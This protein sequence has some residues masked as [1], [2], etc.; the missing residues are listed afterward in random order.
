M[1]VHG[2]RRE[3][4]AAEESG[5]C[6][7]LSVITHPPRCHSSAP[8]RVCAFMCLSLSFPRPWWD[9]RER[10]KVTVLPWQQM[11]TINSLFFFFYVIVVFHSL[12]T[13]PR[14]L[15][16]WIWSSRP[17]VTR[18]ILAHPTQTHTHMQTHTLTHALR[19]TACLC[20]ASV[21]WDTVDKGDSGGNGSLSIYIS[22][23]WGLI[24]SARRLTKTIASKLDPP[25]CSVYIQLHMQPL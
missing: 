23:V 21:W 15:L 8:I 5:R 10:L 13:S 19:G 7:V 11:C 9:A 14:G 18:Q 3:E 25:P 17:V 12:C 6:W 1:K 4:G 24:S 16:L 2:F 22:C 20:L